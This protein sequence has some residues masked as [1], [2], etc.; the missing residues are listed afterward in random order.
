MAS[1]YS[2][3]EKVYKKESWVCPYCRT[4]YEEEQEAIKC[5]DS[6]YSDSQIEVEALDYS[7]K[8]PFPRVIKVRS[9]I[10]GDECIYVKSK[11]CGG[12]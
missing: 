6:H 8:H 4:E 9:I 11:D 12:W 7:P 2:E 1:I 3:R 5:W 10:T